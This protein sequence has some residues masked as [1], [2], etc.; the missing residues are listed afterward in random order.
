MN[1]VSKAGAPENVPRARP[2]TTMRF[3][4]RGARPQ[5]WKP[6]NFQVAKARARTPVGRGLSRVQAQGSLGPRHR[7]RGKVGWGRGRAE[8]KARAWL[9]NPPGRGGRGRRHPGRYLLLNLPVLCDDPVRGGEGPSSCH[10]QQGGKAE[11][12][13]WAGT[14]RQL[15]PAADPYCRRHLAPP[16]PATHTGSGNGSSRLAILVRSA[17]E[18]EES[19]G[20]CPGDSLIPRP[21]FGQP[22]SVASGADP[23]WLQVGDHFVIVFLCAIRSWSVRTRGREK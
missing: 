9:R 18:E 3:F 21:W 5:G 15:A 10:T 2:P 16:S 1:L 13:A 7:D 17:L 14:R 20:R 8:P 23:V 11:E 4:P 6:E 19:R 22:L 12:P